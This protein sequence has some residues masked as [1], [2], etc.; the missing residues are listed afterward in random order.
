MLETIKYNNIK[1]QIDS[2]IREEVV[3][4][5]EPIIAQKV[6]P[7]FKNPESLSKSIKNYFAYQP[8]ILQE[9][10]QCKNQCNDKLV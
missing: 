4:I 5:I 2:K 8:N 6:K 1:D 10:L 3:A 9:E 7:L